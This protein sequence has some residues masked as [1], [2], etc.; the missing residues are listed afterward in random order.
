MFLKEVQ[1]YDRE[2]L[3][4]QG[5]P[6]GREDVPLLSESLEVEAESP[7]T[8]GVPEAGTEVEEEEEEDDEEKW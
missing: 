2:M 6:S 4:Y 3:E 7:Q 8:V 1:R 5:G